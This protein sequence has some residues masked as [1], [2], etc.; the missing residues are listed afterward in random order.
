MFNAYIL[1]VIEAERWAFPCV[2]QRLSREGFVMAV[3]E[4]V[5]TRPVTLDISYQCA[6]IMWEFHVAR[7]FSFAEFIGARTHNCSHEQRSLQL[8]LRQRYTGVCMCLYD[9]MWSH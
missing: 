8:Y 2:L 4:T 9:A 1:Y 5:N 6:R 3:Q 7:H